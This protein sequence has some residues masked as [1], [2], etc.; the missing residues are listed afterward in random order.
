MSII[1]IYL[2]FVLLV[3]LAVVLLAVYYMRKSLS[4]KITHWLLLI[5]TSVLLLATVIVLF[6]TDIENISLSHA[7]EAQERD[8]SKASSEFSEAI[9]NG[10]SPVVDS[11]YIVEEKSFVVDSSVLTINTNWEH[12]PN[13]VVERIQND[14]RSIKAQVYSFS[15]Y[16]ADGYDLTDRVIPPVVKLSKNQLLISGPGFKEA[17]LSVA[18]KEF[19]ISQFEKGRQSFSNL[20]FSSMEHYVIYLQVP[21]GVEIKAPEDVYVEY[22]Q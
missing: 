1:S 11:K 7:N 5:Y 8:I 21:E 3:L 15:N 19:P 10:K 18:T 14:Q 20:G 17:N 2:P 22:L 9:E 16:T 12:S 6:G 4:V 13:V